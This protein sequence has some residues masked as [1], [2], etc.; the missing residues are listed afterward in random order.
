MKEKKPQNINMGQ[1][2]RDAR[3]AKGWTREQ[4]AEHMDLSVQFI[5]DL[6]LGNSGV[7]LDRFAELC[8][9]LGVNAHTVLFG[10]VEENP[11]LFRLGTL[12]ANRDSKDVRRVIA[13]LEALTETYFDTL[14]TQH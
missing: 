1:R 9:L 5:A 7:R 4:L 10:T 3:E 12:L 8:R 13:M 11:A 2:F 6:E 14:D